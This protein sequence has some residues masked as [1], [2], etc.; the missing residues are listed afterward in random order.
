MCAGIIDHFIT[1]ASPLSNSRMKTM[2]QA[3][4]MPSVTMGK[5]VG[6]RG[7]SVNGIIE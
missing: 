6:R 5:L 4:T 1:K 3:T 7:T 2:K